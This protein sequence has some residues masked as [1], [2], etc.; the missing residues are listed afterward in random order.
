MRSKLFSLI[1]LLL[2]SLGLVASVFAQAPAD[3][4]AS[5]NASATSQKAV[6]VL[7]H[8]RQLYSEEGARVALPAFEQALAL[9]REHKDAKGDAI[10][11]GLI[12][13]CYQ[14]LGDHAQALDYL[15]RALA[16]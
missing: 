1:I 11:L 5:D 13:N 8:A 10:M 4:R 12:G 7:A 9:F 15:Q 3:S 16:M 6:D 2:A 14:K